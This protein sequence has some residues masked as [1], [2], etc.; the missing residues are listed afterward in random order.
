MSA[1]RFQKEAIALNGINAYISWKNQ[2]VNEDFNYDENGNMIKV[3]HPNAEI[4]ISETFGK[5]KGVEW[6]QD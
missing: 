3:Q 5:F 2:I 4:Y 1:T 6:Q